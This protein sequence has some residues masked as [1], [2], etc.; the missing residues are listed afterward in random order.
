MDW[1]GSGRLFEKVES[2]GT[3]KSEAELNV[4]CKPRR[5][6]RSQHQDLKPDG[7]SPPGNFYGIHKE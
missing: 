3:L 2:N 5:Q 7:N 6:A 1:L 4:Q